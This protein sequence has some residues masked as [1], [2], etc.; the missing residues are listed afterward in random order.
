MQTFEYPFLAKLVYRY[1]NIPVTLILLIYFLV[2]LSALSESWFWVFS[3]IIHALLIFFINRYYWRSYKRFPYKIEINNE[4]M[5]CS[6]FFLSS[7]KIEIQLIDIEELKGGI[8]S[9]SLTKPIFLKVKGMNS[10]IGFHY[11]LKNYNNLLT[12]ILS[13]ISQPLYNDL[14]EKM[15]ERGL[16]KRAKRKEK[17]DKRSNKKKS[18]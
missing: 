10:E 18:R 9:S 7:K 2:S 15:K 14:L 3:S 12:I 8:F 13:N 17:R 11:H 16:E 6:N 5:I 4:K 1:A